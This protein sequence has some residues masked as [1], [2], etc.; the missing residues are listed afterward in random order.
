[1]FLSLPLELLVWVCNHVDEESLLALRYV[2]RKLYPIATERLFSLISSEQPGPLYR[3]VRDKRLDIAR[4]FLTKYSADINA[5][6]AGCTPILLAVEA[7]NLEAVK[8]LLNEEDIDV[9]Y[10]DHSGHSPLHCA[11]LNSSLAIFERLISFESTNVNLPNW[12]GIPPITTSLLHNQSYMLQALLQHPQ[13]EVN[14]LDRLDQS[15]VM[16]AVERENYGA[17]HILGKDTRADFNC[18]DLS[19]DTPL[20]RAVKKHTEPSAIK[21][22]DCLLCCN[23]IDIN[24][25]DKHL[26][27]T[28]WY[29]VDSCS[30]SLVRLLLDREGLE[31]NEVDANG[32]TPLAVAATR[33]NL[34]I[35]NLLLERRNI[36]VNAVSPGAVSPLLAACSE[37]DTTIVERLVEQKGI[38]INEIGRAHTRLLACSD[39]YKDTSYSLCTPLICACT[40]G[41]LDIVRLLINN[42]NL[43]LNAVDGQGRTAFCWAAARGDRKIC[44]LLLAQPG[45]RIRL[46]DVNGV[47]AYHAPKIYRHPLVSVLCKALR[48]QSTK[49]RF[50]RYS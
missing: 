38:A 23:N 27:T 3:A 8:F 26:R 39:R 32:W 12:M 42:E 17:L 43:D 40:M 14:A 35:L 29:A 44:C 41:Y 28:F 49:E 47:T 13:I 30:E 19:G 45:I 20:L 50:S 36:L 7:R 33:G 22:V 24:S 1:M 15:P 16:W 37:N 5:E 6:Y 25:K 2:S 11:I 34:L 48:S 46:E 4:I 21:L 10:Q 18:R 9:N 31:I